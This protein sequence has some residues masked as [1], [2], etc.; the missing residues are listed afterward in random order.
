MILQAQGGPTLAA[1]MGIELDVDGLQAWR[2]PFRMAVN[3]QLG[4]I[5]RWSQSIPEVGW[6]GG[7]FQQGMR[8]E[9]LVEIIDLDV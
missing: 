6:G 2:R 9:W 8:R 3:A 4:L 7:L 1:I 5:D